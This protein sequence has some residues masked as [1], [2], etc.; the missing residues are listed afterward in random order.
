MSQSDPA[1][2]QSKSSRTTTTAVVEYPISEDWF[3]TLQRPW[4]TIK[5]SDP[6]AA[7]KGRPRFVMEFFEAAHLGG[8]EYD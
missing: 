1:R 3:T 5:D 7:L 6:P 8:S 2:V 4:A